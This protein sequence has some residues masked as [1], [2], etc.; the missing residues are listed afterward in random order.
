MEQALHWYVRAAG[1]GDADAQNRLGECCYYGIGVKMDSNQAGIFWEQAAS[2]GMKQAEE[3]LRL[4][5]ET[6]SSPELERQCRRE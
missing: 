4:L 3:N 5:R 6:G 2:H 1:H